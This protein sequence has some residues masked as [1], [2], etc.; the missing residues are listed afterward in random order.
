M[1]RYGTKA[2]PTVVGTRERFT[3]DSFRRLVGAVCVVFIGGWVAWLVGVVVG[4]AYGSRQLCGMAIWTGFCFG[5][6][7]EC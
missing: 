2:S 6:R 5:G 4:V 1:Y 3:V 7:T